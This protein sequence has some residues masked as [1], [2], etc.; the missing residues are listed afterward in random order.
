[1]SISQDFIVLD[2]YQPI[3][4]NDTN[5]YQ[6]EI[7][8][9]NELIKD[10]V[11]LGYERIKISSQQELLSNVKIQLERLNKIKFSENEWKRFILEYLDCPSDDIT[12][13]SQ[14]IHKNYIYDF[15]FDDGSIN[16]IYLIDKK[17][18]LNNKVQVINQ[19]QQTGLYLNRYDVTILV[20]GLPL[21]QVEL[22][23]RGVAIK[24]AFNQIHRYSKESFNSESSLFKYLQ[25]FVISNG[26][27]TRYFANTTERNEK[28]FN[29][30]INWATAQNE[31]IL[32]LKDFTETFFQK[33]T[34]LN[35]LINYSIL[36][37][38][39]H[40]F[41]MRP[42]QIA[43]TERILFKIKNSYYLNVNEGLEKGGFIWHT[44][45]SGKT[46]TSFKTAQMATELDFIDKVL[47]IVD[48]QD[49]D[50]QTMKEY[51]NYS[52]NSVNG[53]DNT[54]ELKCNLESTN[55]KIIVTTIHKLN[56]FVKK[57]KNHQIFNKN[58]V[59]IFDECHRSNFGEYHKNIKESFNK[60]FKFG[61]TG[62]PIKKENSLTPDEITENVF[63]KLLHSYI[64]IDAIK[65]GKVLKFKIEYNNVVPKFK[66]IEEEKNDFKLS[67]KEVQE[68]FLQPL[69]INKISNYILDTFKFKTNRNVGS[70][71]NAM[72]AV[73]SIEAA[74][75]YYLE[76]NELQ[77]NNPNKINIATIF[78]FNQ[79]EESFSK[80]GNINDE[81]FEVD[82]M[83]LNS[84][85]FLSEVIS[86]YNSLFK[87]NFDVTT[88]QFQSYYKDLSN[89]LKEG[90]VDLVIVVGMFL[91]GF[92]S[93]VLNTLF[94]DKNLKYH[95]LLQ[96]FSRTNRILD[97]TKQFGNIV[98]FR[99][100]ESATNDALKLFGTRE[101]N[102]DKSKYEEYKSYVLEKSYEE[103]IN[104]FKDS[105]SENRGYKNIVNDLNKNFNNIEEIVTEKQKKEFVKTFN[106]FLKIESILNNFD[107][108]HILKEMKS[109]QLNN[110][111]Q[112]EKFK[113]KYNLN[114]VDLDYMKKIDYLSVRKIQNYTSKY[115]DILTEL[116]N[117]KNKS[118]KVNWE[119][120][121]F[122]VDLLKSVE[123]NLDYI[124]KLI[125][126]NKTNENKEKIIEEVKRLIKTNLGNRAKESLIV[127]FISKTNL[128]NIQSQE[129]IIEE[130]LIFAKK[131][132]DKDLENIIKSENLNLEQTK[133]YI[134]IAMK[135]EF[136]SENGTDINSIIPKMSPLNPSYL[137]KKEIV[138]NKISKFVDKFKKLNLSFKN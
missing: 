85:E 13:K 96:A 17:N 88:K 98:T 122:E 91:T 73:S 116:K 69:R 36:N 80:T 41:V 40:L 124:F 78:S 136:V 108:F 128:N 5:I 107:N 18:L 10:L 83:D 39:N 48:R 104:G 112:V 28:N 137:S 68:A 7:D 129:G 127:D 106:E 132:F 123:V 109:I 51:Q 31:N 100:L 34:F 25:I 93:Q 35:V 50:Y 66:Q 46:L 95:G 135:K 131:E 84:K 21:V 97:N 119:E 1:M 62:T 76:L 27:D 117:E 38:D 125:F 70:K 67:Q 55:N 14:K 45:G 47:F 43:A 65:D 94:V 99:N 82:K 12:E 72:F 19:F 114:D 2:K 56:I 49:L 90:E 30:T 110:K 105:N 101:T 9:E 64:I 134:D 23:K 54:Y 118:S 87:T 37:V 81:D 58:V 29:S 77:K 52:P 74:K 120:I 138:F 8:L 20:N 89:R 59:L 32:D 60:C 15:M 133:A 111:E 92:D 4:N 63:G 16:N 86:D 121:V 61:F 3:Q 33:N 130:F 53:S 24:E 113:N 6:R 115:N 103:Y 102:L 26:T 11:N 22:K 126:D 42:Y 75:K 79:N 44:P 71:F 57:Y